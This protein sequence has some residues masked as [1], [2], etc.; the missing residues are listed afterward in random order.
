VIALVALLLAGTVWDGVRSP[1]HISSDNTQ[2]LRK[3]TRAYA[4]L[5]AIDPHGVFLARGDFFG[6]NAD[7]LSA[8][9]PFENPNFVPLGWAT[10]SPLF[11]ARLARLGIHDL[12]RALARN[13][14]V[15]LYATGIEVKRVALYFKQHRGPVEFDKASTQTL[16]GN[17]VWRFRLAPPVVPAPPPLPRPVGGR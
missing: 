1:N 6:L 12:Y 4:A 8:H 15:Y 7:P 5:T 16:F 2:A 10:N 11:N 14:H 3:R 9:T 13:P 17:Y